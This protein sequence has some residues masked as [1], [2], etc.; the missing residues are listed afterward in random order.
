MI[1]KACNEPFADTNGNLNT[2][3]G[4]GLNPLNSNLPLNDRICQTMTQYDKEDES[5]HGLLTPEKLRSQK[6]S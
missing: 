6:K 4:C 2:I 1:L 5:K 3:V